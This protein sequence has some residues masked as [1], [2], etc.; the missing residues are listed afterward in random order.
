MV[1]GV[2]LGLALGA[3]V[4]HFLSHASDGGVASW[5]WGGGGCHGAQA[6]GP[7]GQLAVAQWS[8]VSTSGE[9]ARRTARERIGRWLRGLPG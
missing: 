1:L 3:V 7:G 6:S 8:P 2:V 9:S 5:G 4:G